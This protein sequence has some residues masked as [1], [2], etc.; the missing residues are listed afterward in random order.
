MATLY[1]F[2]KPLLDEGEIVFRAPPANERDVKA[3]PLLRQAFDA[4]RLQVAGPELPFR[5]NAALRTA[6]YLR[7]ACWFLVHRG[8]ADDALKNRLVLAPPGDA[9]DHL[10]G[11]VMLRFLP[12][13][14]RRAKSLAPAD[15]LPALLGQT[16]REWPLSGVL[17]DVPD[18]PL[19]APNF[20]GHPGLLLLYAERL[21]VQNKPEWL[22][23]GRGLEYVELVNHD[24]GK[25]LPTFASLDPTCRKTADG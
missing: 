17:S 23:E 5:E 3:L 8:E 15:P 16:L 25:P 24:L 11:D 12:Q 1:E 21:A 7:Q 14:Y 4:H 19:T 13:V 22:P 6:E 10:T 9:P 20:D 18:R 2:L